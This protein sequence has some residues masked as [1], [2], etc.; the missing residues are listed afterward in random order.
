MTYSNQLHGSDCAG[1]LKSGSASF[2]SVRFYH[3]R[4]AGI[5]SSGRHLVIFLSNGSAASATVSS[6]EVDE[7]FEGKILL[8]PRRHMMVDLSKEKLIRQRMLAMILLYGSL[9][10]QDCIEAI[11]L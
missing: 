5:G 2:K 10:L 9:V 6:T 8:T 3:L 11:L 7:S 1:V 4:A